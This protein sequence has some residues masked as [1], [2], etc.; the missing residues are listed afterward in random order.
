MSSNTPHFY[1]RLSSLLWRFI[2][3][4]IVLL[5]VYVS[6]GR[7]LASHVDQYR[8]PIIDRINRAIPGH[9]EA[10]RIA[11]RW[12]SFSPTLILNQVVLYGDSGAIAG[13]R[14]EF[15]AA[16]LSVDIFAS[17]RLWVPSVSSLVVKGLKVEYRIDSNTDVATRSTNSTQSV[18]FLSQVLEVLM[19]KTRRL[20]I[21]DARLRVNREGKYYQAALEFDYW[22]DGSERQ[23]KI[24]IGD[25]TGTDIQVLAQGLGN[26]LR[27]EEFNGNGYASLTMNQEP[28]EVVSGS[29]PIVAQQ[30]AGFALE[31]Y[32][33]AQADDWRLGG[34]W[35]FSGLAMRNKRVDNQLYGEFRVDTNFRA[36]TARVFN[37]GLD[38]HGEPLDLPDITSHWR[39]DVLL[40]DSDTLN[41]SQL[42]RL[43]RE[44]DPNGALAKALEEL[45]PQG[46]LIQ[47]RV[48]WQQSQ[49]KLRAHVKLDGLSVEASE[50]RAGGRGVTGDLWLHD[51]KAML[52]LNTPMLELALPTVYAQPLAIANATA[53]LYA[54][55]DADVLHLRADDI[56]G[57]AAV[58]DTHGKLALKLP[59]KKGAIAPEMEL[60]LGVSEGNAAARN[61]VIPVTIPE[62]L[63]AWLDTAIGEASA[64]DFGFFYRGSL[65]KEERDARSLGLVG[66]IQAADL[67]FLPDWP[68][69]H[70]DSAVLVM[71]DEQTG[72]WFDHGRLPGLVIRSVGAEVWLDEERQPH[73]NIDG[74]IQ[75]SLDAALADLR[76]SPLTVYLPQASA[77]W[78]TQGAIAGRLTIETPLSG[79]VRP[80]VGLSLNLSDVSI[81]PVPGL[82]LNNIQGELGY[83]TQS[84]FSAEALAGSVWGQPLEAR[85]V[86]QMGEV[87]TTQIQFSTTLHGPSLESFMSLGLQG[88]LQGASLVYGALILA[89]EQAT[90]QLTSDL[91]GLEIDLPKPLAKAADASV[92]MRF[93]LDLRSPEL[94][95]S[96][97]LGQAISLDAQFAPDQR[98]FAVGL[99]RAPL[100]LEA[101]MSSLTGSLTQLDIDAWRAVLPPSE[102]TSQAHYLV[103]DLRVDQLRFM[104]RDIESI[105]LMADRQASDWFVGWQTQWLSGELSSKAEDG[106]WNLHLIDLDLQQLPD[107]WAADVESK[108]EL[109]SLPKLH[110]TLDQVRQGEE[111]LGRGEL[112]LAQTDTDYTLTARN[113]EWRKLRAD[114]DQ[115]ITLTWPKQ[116][117]ITSRVAGGLLVDNLGEVFEA[118][119]YES[120]LKTRSGRADFDLKWPGG[121]EQFGFAGTDGQLKIR[122][123]NGKFLKASAG[124]QGALK[125]ITILNFADIVSRLS[126]TQLFE[127]GVPFDQLAIDATADLGLINIDKMNMESSASRFQFSGQA[128]LLDESLDGRL[129]ATLPVASNLPWLAALTGGLPAAAGVY[130][131]SKIFEK[132]VDKFSSAVYSVK[133]TWQEPE[134]AFDTLFDTK[135][136]KPKA[137]AKPDGSAGVEQSQTDTETTEESDASEAEN[138]QSNPDQ[139]EDPL[140]EQGTSPD[141]SFP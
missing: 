18:Q 129:I 118:F 25:S 2:V 73:L 141:L 123:Q 65:V 78:E 135:L 43:L 121:P 85:I 130:V 10:E 19:D 99:G 95:G 87:A 94:R 29:A 77:S 12:E 139:S 116:G 126:L 111:I 31:A 84:G 51:N 1:D 21:S 47:P 67:K 50:K 4:S 91:K 76:A 131:I 100:P 138:T 112:S 90:L 114:P 97:Q 28:L 70:I 46:H 134:L 9:L 13:T 32:L 35:S 52:Q 122:L 15:E 16:E 98:G 79:V 24:N 106:H 8:E 132:Q 88:R 34:H 23:L 64:S 117:L 40:V 7:L 127:S 42:S 41:L 69:L 102:E 96:L 3:F 119:G 115:P 62:N 27:P 108:E 55:W 136:P 38:A 36:T 57:S 104:Q 53:D 48:L 60:Y 137:G 93:D 54:S 58:G 37:L 103:Q 110:I 63:Q 45:E 105:V 128:N 133:G 61:T 14:V 56:H 125:V 17:L 124:A 82:S 22:R 33:Q 80:K 5:A 81:T 39:D 20:D 83:S 92:A 107:V 44:V 30:S 66:R 6:F 89:P 71:D 109:S 11:L 101:G 68:A 113:G 59:F 140:P 49:H 75:G 72:I 74:S 86:T 120:V 26:P